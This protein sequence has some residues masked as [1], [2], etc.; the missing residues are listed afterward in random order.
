MAYLLFVF[1][2]L[3]RM[4]YGST[5][6]PENNMHERGEGKYMLVDKTMPFQESTLLPFLPPT[7]SQQSMVI[8]LF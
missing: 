2:I 8:T 4:Y 7:F 6:I 1:T 3:E 5:R